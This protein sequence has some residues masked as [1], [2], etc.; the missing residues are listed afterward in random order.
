MMKR[1]FTTLFVAVIALVTFSCDDDERVIT[2]DGLPEAAK[3]F[4]ADHFT[5]VAIIRIIKDTEGSTEYEVKLANGFKIEFNSKGAWREVEGYGL[6]VPA[7]ILTE[8]PTAIVTYVETN[9]AA[10]AITKLEIGR[11]GNYEVDLVGNIEIVFSSTGEFI[12]Y[13]D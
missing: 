10:N 7:S 11:N 2:Q 9:H 5:D 6:P 4:L 13:D 1:I 8:I 3:V 12:R